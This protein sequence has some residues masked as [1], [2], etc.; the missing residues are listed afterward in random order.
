MTDPET[1]LRTLDAAEPFTAEQRRHAGTVLERIVATAPEQPRP[2][3]RR[4]LVPVAAAAATVLA[5]AL[6][7][8]PGGAGDSP[9]YGSWTSVPTGLSAA[10]IALVG[11]AC[12][13]ELG[14]GRSD[15]DRATLTL[16]ER[17]GEYAVLLY[18][19]ADLAGACLAHNV[20]GSADVDDVVAGA[21]S[22]SS[23]TAPARGYRDGALADFRGASITEGVVGAEVT[24]VTIHA[25][26]RTVQ[27]TVTGGRYVA[28]WPGPSFDRDA[29]HGPRLFLTYDLTLRDGTILTDVAPAA[30]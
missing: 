14:W 21:A 27:A 19:D 24:G 23:G 12:L 10:E 29:A 2:V 16:A 3:R 1:T 28:W 22:G 5:A 15:R 18:R 17:R 11:P 13:D 8:W 7:V 9:A 30:P 20:P 4:R 6:V 25:R 26:S